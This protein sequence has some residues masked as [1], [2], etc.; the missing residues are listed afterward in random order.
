MLP[1]CHRKLYENNP[2]CFFLLYYIQGIPYSLQTRYLP[3]IFMDSG[4]ARLYISLYKLAIVPWALK[5]IW[6]PMPAVRGNAKRTWLI[7]S[8]ACLVVL[9]LILSRYPPWHASCFTTTLILYNLAAS[10]LDVALNSLVDEVSEAKRVTY[11]DRMQLAGNY[12]GALTV[13]TLAWITELIKWQQ[14]F[15]GLA[16]LYFMGFI[17]S[18]VMLPRWETPRTRE[19][20]SSGRPE[21]GTRCSP[22]Q[23]LYPS[24]DNA[25][26]CYY[27]YTNKFTKAYTSKILN[28]DGSWWLLTLLAVYKIGK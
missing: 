3:L 7:T 2:L 6:A 9:C 23:D 20:S 25:P 17:I 19:I 13:G 15:A 21:T 24:P 18:A 11:S 10:L 28:F 27:W 22:S 26:E 12:A 16:V 1:R 8:L 5:I 14:L 4:M